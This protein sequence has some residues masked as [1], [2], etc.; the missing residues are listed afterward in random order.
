MPRFHAGHH[1]IV[2]AAPNTIVVGKAIR[3]LF[4]GF[5]H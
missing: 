4:T 2:C 1:A 3:S 5:N